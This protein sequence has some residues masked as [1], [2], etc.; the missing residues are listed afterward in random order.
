MKGLVNDKVRAAETQP[1][2]SLRKH[3][4]ELS[5]FKKSGKENEELL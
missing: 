4:M 3:W 5:R 1:F 2:F